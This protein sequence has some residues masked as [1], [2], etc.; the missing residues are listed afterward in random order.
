METFIQLGDNPGLE[1]DISPAYYVKFHAIKTEQSVLSCTQELLKDLDKVNL[2]LSGGIDSQF[3][4]LVAKELKKDI[5][6]YTYRAMWDNTI[7]NAEDVYMAQHMSDINDVKLNILD[8]N[9]RKFFDN[10]MHF[11]YGKE[12]GNTSPQLSV[13]LHWID[14]LHS[15]YKIK[16]ILMGGDPPLFKYSS[17]N[18]NNNKVRMNDSFYQ[19]ILTPYYL[20]CKSKNILCLRD[21]YYHNPKI[22]YAGFKNNIDVVAKKKIYIEN[23]IRR[24]KSFDGTTHRSASP[25][26]TDNYVFKYE[27]YSN[28]IEGLIPQQSGITGFE[29]LKKILASESGAYNRF[30]Q[31]YRYPMWDQGVNT[32]RMMIKTSKIR[33]K[34]RN[35]I[36]PSEIINLFK[37]FQTQ[38]KKSE[39]KPVN[40]YRFDF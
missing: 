11:Q 8:I 27:W 19:D 17:V 36:V 38:V 9:L 35:I 18:T 28:I 34:S 22:V 29:T 15:K 31:L 25:F 39:A 1:I 12:Y 33:N 7:V 14:L 6:A 21:M 16:N 37:K 10:N 24:V 23:D 5:T 30:D 20:F 3:S 26:L 32:V 13:H 4:L 40:R 2:S